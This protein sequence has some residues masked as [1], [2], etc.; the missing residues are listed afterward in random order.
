MTV[1]VS[2]AVGARLNR[3]GVPWQRIRVVPNGIDRARFDRRLPAPRTAG[4]RTAPV[5]IV[6]EYH[7]GVFPSFGPEQRVDR[8]TERR[9]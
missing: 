1:A 6:G 7:A 8:V 3:W 9:R 2:P 5:R 4:A